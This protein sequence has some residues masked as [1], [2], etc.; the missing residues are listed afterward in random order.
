MFRFQ[1][2]DV[3]L[4]M[5]PAMRGDAIAFRVRLDGD[6]PGDAHG[7][8]VDAAVLAREEPRDLARLRVVDRAQD[9]SVGLL[10]R[11]GQRG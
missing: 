11:H 10:D 3:N 8:D 2:R 7:D 1:A 4:V 9:E 6:A 5:A